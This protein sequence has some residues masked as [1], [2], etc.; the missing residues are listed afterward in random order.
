MYNH[1]R[2]SYFELI[3]ISQ[4]PAV[5]MPELAINAVA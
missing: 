2:F 4:M 5:K 3:R 1:Y